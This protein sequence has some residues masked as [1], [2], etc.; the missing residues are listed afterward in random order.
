MIQLSVLY[1]T[2]P[3]AC[4]AMTKMSSLRLEISIVVM[5]GYADQSNS[6]RQEHYRKPKTSNFG[7]CGSYGKTTHH[8]CVRAPAQLNARA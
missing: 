2:L 8:D 5:V 3:K 7:R 4:K 6:A 1:M